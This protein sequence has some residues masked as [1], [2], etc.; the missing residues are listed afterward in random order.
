MI[1][2]FKLEALLPDLDFRPEYLGEFGGV[3]EL[4]PNNQ[5]NS[6][7]ECRTEPFRVKIEI[8]VTEF[9]RGAGS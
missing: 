7:S 8:V 2:H 5:P 4:K 3:G 1:G 6:C 9:A